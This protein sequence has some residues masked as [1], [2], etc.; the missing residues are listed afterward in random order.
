MKVW[1][2]QAIDAVDKLDAEKIAEIGIVFRISRAP[3]R[4]VPLEHV[5]GSGNLVH[6]V[7][8]EVDGIQRAVGC[9]YVARI[10]SASASESGAR[11]WRQL[12]GME[13]AEEDVPSFFAHAAT[14]E[15]GDRAAMAATTR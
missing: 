4:L 15:E 13:P 10:A 14:I 8:L 2:H 12:H 5:D 6:R 11:Y 7:G 9:R 3:L 1:A